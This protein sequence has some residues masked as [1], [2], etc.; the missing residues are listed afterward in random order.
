MDNGLLLIRQH[1]PPTFLFPP[2][3][4]SPISLRLIKETFPQARPFPPPFFFFFPL[5]VSSAW[6]CPQKASSFPLILAEASSQAE[7]FFY[8][9]VSGSFFFPK[10]KNVQNSPI[11]CKGAARWFLGMIC[12]QKTFA[13]D[14][15]SL[16][17]RWE[18]APPRD[19]RLRSSCRITALFPL[20]PVTPPGVHLSSPPP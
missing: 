19:A 20:S 10:P 11:S 6:L 12:A 13:W 4:R 3:E 15:P 7:D 14:Q 9:T 16:S 5:R 2:D 17:R 18:G 1:H 8:S